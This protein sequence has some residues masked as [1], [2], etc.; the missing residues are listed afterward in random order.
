MNPAA[1]TATHPAPALESEYRL[2]V[3]RT[4]PATPDR[5]FAAWTRPEL[6]RRWL[7]PGTATVEEVEFDVRVGGSYRL[8]MVSPDGSRHCSSGIYEEIIPNERLVFSWQWDHID[9]LVTRVTVELKPGGDS[10]TELKLV[11][12]G[13]TDSELRD[14]H[15]EGW[16]GCFDKLAPALAVPD[17]S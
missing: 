15:E 7:A 11:H 12:E 9:D 3:R 2:V 14:K 16:N 6:V 17:R 10:E 13:L 5:V 1:D 8:A 4:L